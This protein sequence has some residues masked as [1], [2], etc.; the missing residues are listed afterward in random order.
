MVIKRRIT[1]AIFIIFAIIYNIT[2]GFKEEEWVELIQNAKQNVFDL[3]PLTWNPWN[4]KL[5][6]PKEILIIPLHT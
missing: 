5:N 6:S 4:M 1:V 3:G 2:P